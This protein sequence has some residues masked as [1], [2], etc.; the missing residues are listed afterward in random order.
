MASLVEILIKA[1]DQVSA[2]IDGITGSLDGLGKGAEDAEQV[3][4]DAFG[5]IFDSA[6]DAF[7]GINQGVELAIKAFDLLK[8][9]YDATVGKVLEIANEVGELSRVSGDAPENMSALRLEAEKAKVP[10]EDLYKAM[11]NLNK[12]GIAPTVENLVA[13]AQEYVNLQDPVAQAAF[14][15]ENFGSA[16]QEIAPMLVSIAG[17]I[18]DV[19]DAG[20]IFTD[21]D[22][23]SVK[24][25]EQAVA[26]LKSTWENFAVSAGKYL[27]PELTGG[28]QLFGEATFGTF[29]NAIELA[30][31][32]QTSIKLLNEQFAKDRSVSNYAAGLRDMVKS[33][34]S[35]TNENWG[36]V[37]FIEDMN[38]QLGKTPNV[39]EDVAYSFDNVIDKT[40]EWADANYESGGAVLSATAA[41]REQKQAASD[42]Q[43]QQIALLEASKEEIKLYGALMNL[44]KQYTPILADIGEMQAR[45]VELNSIKDT[46][47]YLDGVWVSAKNA[48]EEMAK[49]EEE[50]QNAKLAMEGLAAQAVAG[51]AWGQITADAQVSL[52]EITKY[53]DYLVASGIMSAEAGE[54]AIR[55]FMEF[56][57]LWDPEAKPLPVETVM[58]SSESD[59][60]E[61]PSKKQLVEAQLDAS[62][63]DGYTPPNKVMWVE[64]RL[65]NRA[66]D[67]AA[68]GVVNA[69]A[70]VAAGL[71]HYWVGER[72][73]EPFFPSVDGR[74][75]SNTQAMSA[76]R[77]GAG[78]NSREI[79]NA[80]RDGVKDAM[81]ETKAGNIYNLT[82][83]TSNNPADVRTAFELMEAWA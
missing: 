29:D 17:G 33:F 69:A 56:W 6:M 82:M 9:A 73:P 12:N 45:I 59:G 2:V 10:F 37:S 32:Y 22:I 52:E 41:L 63:V 19:Q 68:G 36:F 34:L 3:S 58:D 26:E 28:L 40:K 62:D 7:V 1:K 72:G 61:P 76:L 13:I 42:Y 51:I 30:G 24:D 50:I 43:Q 25:Y 20:L 21:E 44:G 77:G 14:L 27:L 66:M 78:V 47:G 8:G 74:I 18:A 54:Q 57:G 70:G 83:P 15:T 31:Q 23:Q 16:G 64:T 5:D 4:S 49:L 67:R 65:L 75:V 80:V 71:S 55:D 81:R 53:Y 38:N 46:G 48:K 60:Y 35:S 39:A 11:E 79:A